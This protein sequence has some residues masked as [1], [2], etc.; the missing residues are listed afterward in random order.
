[1]RRKNN[2]I[3]LRK[4]RKVDSKSARRKRREVDKEIKNFYWVKV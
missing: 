3:S 4:A 1:M 2:N